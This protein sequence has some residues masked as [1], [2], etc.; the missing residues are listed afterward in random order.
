METEKV[1]NFVDEQT[2]NAINFIDDQTMKV[3]KFTNDQKVKLENTIINGYKEAQKVKESFNNYISEKQELLSNEFNNYM[4]GVRESSEINVT[5]PSITSRLNYPEMQLSVPSLVIKN[6]YK[7]ETHTIISQGYMLNAHRIPGRGETVPKKTVLLQHGIFASSADWILNGPK[8]GLAYVL[9]DAGYDVWMTNIR[10]NKYSRE[11]LTLKTNSKEYWDFSWHEVAEFDIPAV[12]DY[13]R[14]LKGADTRITYIGHSMGTTILFAMLTLRPEYN[15]VLNAG[16][17]LAPVAFMTDVQSPLKTFAAL[18]S[19][20]LYMEMIYGL[21]EFLPKDSILGKL[22]SSCHADSINVEVC[23]NVV[24]YLCGRDEEQFN[25][26]LLPVFMSNLGTGTSWKT[27]TH[28]AQ[29]I[30]SGGRFQHFDYGYYKNIEKYGSL[31]PPQY[32]LSKI[33]LNITLFWA[34][35]DLLS[36][37]RDVNKLYDRLPKYTTKYLVPFPK[38]NHLDYLWAVDADTLLNDKI[39]E[40]LNNMKQ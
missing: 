32:D 11:H 31:Q 22:Y 26:A 9:A 35:N 17:A 21:K 28:F 27:A 10:G 34:E 7:C 36:S 33:T 1:Q 19:S 14:R 16:F 3:K 37:A 12:I 2:I 15:D 13:I 24:F 40:L 39:L 25:K 30:T 23:K 6:G 8:K 29:E 4:E 18:T 20:V 38:F 5:P